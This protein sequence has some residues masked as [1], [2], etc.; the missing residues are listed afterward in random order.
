MAIGHFIL[1]VE[2]VPDVDHAVHPRHEEHPCPSRTEASACQVRAVVLRVTVQSAGD[3]DD[4]VLRV[5]SI[6]GK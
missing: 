2:V 5:D 6:R 1:T 3:N 4:N